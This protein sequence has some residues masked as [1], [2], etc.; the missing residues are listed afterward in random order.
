MVY[1]WIFGLLIKYR[2][3]DDVK[4]RKLFLII[5]KFFSKVKIL[6]FGVLGVG[7]I[8]DIKREFGMNM[9]I[10]NKFFLKG[11]FCL[12]LKFFKNFLSVEIIV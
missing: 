3:D 10:F 8:D 6:F 12:I 4:G 5:F 9:N 7:R 2:G 1:S 11:R